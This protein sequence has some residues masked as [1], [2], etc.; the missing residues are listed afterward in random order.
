MMAA[1]AIRASRSASETLPET[2]GSSSGFSAY[3]SKMLAV[4]LDIY[5][6]LKKNRSSIGV[7]MSQT[8]GHFEMD[9]AISMKEVAIGVG[10][11]FK[12]VNVSLLS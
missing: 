8:Q 10:F 4:I 11:Q 5:P 2:L 7:N 6:F 12:I 9:A 3:L 1:V